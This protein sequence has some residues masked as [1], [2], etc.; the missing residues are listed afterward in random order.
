MPSQPII[1]LRAHNH[2]EPLHKLPHT[3]GLTAGQET[4]L[5]VKSVIKGNHLR[6]INTDLYCFI[7]STIEALSIE[8][9]IFFIMA[10]CD[11]ANYGFPTLMLINILNGSG[12]SL[13]TACPALKV[14]LIMIYFYRRPGQ[15]LSNRH[16]TVDC[17][18]VKIQMYVVTKLDNTLKG[19]EACV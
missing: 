10:A 16:Q 18:I 13:S 19:D 17:E 3:T 2:R 6:S 4:I 12:I 14:L 7:Q 15:R 11:H 1:P 5:R 9:S 8:S